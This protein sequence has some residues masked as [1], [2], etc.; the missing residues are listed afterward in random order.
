MEIHTL[1]VGWGVEDKQLDF[2]VYRAIT[3]S[4]HRPKTPDDQK[5]DA[6]YPRLFPIAVTPSHTSASK[7]ILVSVGGL[8]NKRL[9]L[10]A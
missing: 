1:L 9:Y 2:Q 5:T 8:Y 3:G 6:F 7:Q 4:C 10:N